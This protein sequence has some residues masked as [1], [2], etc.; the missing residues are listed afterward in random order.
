MPHQVSPPLAPTMIIKSATPSG[1]PPTQDEITSACT[2][3]FDAQTSQASLDAAY[4]LTNLLLTSVGFRGLKIYGVLEEIKKAAADK[5]SGQ[6]RESAMIILGALLEKYSEKQPISEVIFLQDL[7][8]VPVALDALADKGAVVK[9]SAQ[10]A[11]DALFA[12]LKT[13]ALV[14]GLLPVLIEYLSKRTGKWQGTVGAFELIGRMADK[15]K[16]GMGSREDEKNKDFLREAMGKRLEQLIHVVENGMHDL[17]NEVR[18]RSRTF[19]CV[20]EIIQ[21]TKQRSP[22]KPSRP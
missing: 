2:T 1:I 14:V 18:T 15:A 12:N 17:K 3:V 13:E 16:V 20:N 5:K 10:Y 19:I 4:A 22:N 7:N 9:E 21:L 6:R 11:L 8:M